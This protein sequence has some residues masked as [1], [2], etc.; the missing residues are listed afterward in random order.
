MATRQVVVRCN[1]KT[2]VKDPGVKGVL[3]MMEDRIIFTPND[4]TS[5][6]LTIGLESV[7][8]H[9]FNRKG[10]H[11]EALLNLILDTAINGGRCI[12]EFE[13]F[14]ERDVCWEFIS[15]FLTNKLQSKKSCRKDPKP[16]SEIFSAEQLSTAEMD[17]RM[18]LLE[19]NNELQKL[20]KQ[21]VLSGVLSESEFWVT[22]KE[23]LSTDASKALKQRV[24]FK[25][26]MITDINP[27]PDGRSNKVTFNLTP[28]I[29]DQIFAEKPAVHKA[30]LKFV[31]YK[32]L[33]VEFWRKYCRAK[34]LYKESNVAAVVAAADDDEVI[35]SFFKGDETVAN[36]SRR[37][38][39]RVD[40]TLDME[41][42]QGD[43]YM[44]RD[45]SKGAIDLKC[46]EYNLSHNLNRHAAVVLQGRAEHVALGNTWTVAEAL[47]RSKQ[48][49]L[50]ESATQA[51]RME[52]VYRM[53]AI[54]DLQDP[55]HKLPFAPLSIKDPRQYYDFQH[56]NAVRNVG[57]AEFSTKPISHDLNTQHTWG[58]LKNL[59]S[60][61]RE[62]GFSDPVVRPDVAL[63]VLKDLT[64]HHS[65]TKYHI[66]G[67]SPQ[68]NIL[69]RLENKKEVLHHSASTQELL[70]HFWSSYPITTSYHFTKVS[71]LIDAMSEIYLK[72]QGIK[73]S[74]QS[75]FRHQISQLVQ[76]ML[77]ALDAAFGHYDTHTQ[78][79]GLGKTQ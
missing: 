26:A 28:E 46:D 34:Y 6:K 69:D 62:N 64:Q 47:S 76:P 19:E 71:R 49:G 14:S 20:H 5:V 75:D 43:D 37:K 55:H 56:A 11:K 74:V 4:P 61:M 22:R 13:N 78:N 44:H 63:K 70:K 53:V 8:K 60:D 17:F 18:K 79:R 54:E 72:L 66:I 45:E 51:A 23:L 1:Y 50:D 25:S 40:P 15:K 77:H 31:P 35:A 39:R 12:F 58:S 9:L 73:E 24:G 65:S 36:D 52:M 67:K 42:D 27:V 10:N 59:I 33:E 30:Y 57:D 2:T 7:H 29:I 68:E 21:F 41:A 38:L 16:V 32:F 48:A 3:I